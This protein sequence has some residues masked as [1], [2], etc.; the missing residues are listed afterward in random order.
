[1][2]KW[3]SL[4]LMGLMY[5]AIPFSFAGNLAPAKSSQEEEKMVN[6]INERASSSLPKAIKAKRSE[7]KGLW[8]IALEDGNSVWTNDQVTHVIVGNMMPL[9]DLPDQR[10]SER[11]WEKASYFIKKP[12]H[13]VRRFSAL[14]NPS[15]CL[16]RCKKEVAHLLASKDNQIYVVLMGDSLSPK[17]RST[18]M[19]AKD[20]EQ[21][22]F[23]W[24]KSETWPVKSKCAVRWNNVTKVKEKYKSQTLPA[25]IRLSG[26]SR[27][28]EDLQL[29]PQLSVKEKSK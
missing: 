24:A 14:L 29:T 2:K 1:M 6:M 13:V 22:L 9:S 12:K 16:D 25:L 15:E 7:L 8:E 28:E 17:E 27:L 10:L 19:C 4:A 26:P 3:I 23:A 20:P 21:A 18:W 5:A 11:E